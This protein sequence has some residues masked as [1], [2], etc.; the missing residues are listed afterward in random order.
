MIQAEVEGLR[1][2]GSHD[3]GQEKV[4]I[5]ASA[6]EEFALLNLLVSSGPTSGH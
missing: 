2:G 4:A 6:G 3:Q 5:P 1:T